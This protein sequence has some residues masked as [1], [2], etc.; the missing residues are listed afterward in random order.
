MY[1]S[2]AVGLAVLAYSECTSNLMERRKGER[3]ALGLL[4][5][6]F[7]LDQDQNNEICL[8]HNGACSAAVHAYWR[9]G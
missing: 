3:K 1:C 6:H 7:D 2:A 4:A 9:G 8:R 5:K